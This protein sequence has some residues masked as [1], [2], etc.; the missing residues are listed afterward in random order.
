MKKAKSKKIKNIYFNEMLAIGLPITLQSIFQ[1]SYSLVDQLMVGTLGTVSIAG[2]GLGAKFSSLAMVTVSAIASVASILIAQYHG[3]GDERGVNQ[4]FFSCLYIGLLVMLVFLIPSVWIPETIMGIYSSDEQ[5]VKAAGEYLR[6]IGVSFLPMS[7]TTIVSA[8]LRSTEHSKPPMYAGMASMGINILGNY[9]LIFGHL[10]CPKLG[11]AGAAIGTLI[12][13]SAECLLL[14]G[15][16]LWLKWKRGVFLAPPRRLDKSFYK[17]ISVIILPILF[18]E[19]NWSIGENLYAVIYGRMGTEALAATTLL[20]PLMGLFIGMFNGVSAAAGVMVGKR[21]GNDEKDES[22][23]IAK[24]LVKIGL[25][26]SAVVATVLFVIAGAYVSLFDIEAQVAILAKR[27]IYALA[28]VIFAKISNMILAGGVLRSGGNTQYTLVID[29]IGT[30]VF[31]VPLAFLSACVWKLPIYLVYFI[32]SLEEVV[33]FII[34][35][36]VF[37]KGRWMKNL[38]GSKVTAA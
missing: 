32:L 14:I 23:R 17:K 4:S 18:N 30:W 28:L 27:L 8:Y 5:T 15:F 10:G 6:I 31:G 29:L 21:L 13:R 7:V 12:A 20:N 25:I 36:G 3:A 16:M 19:F 33:R 9:L 38:T 11:L 24:Y 35:I 37:R 34:A 26:G 1:A 2:S 22:I